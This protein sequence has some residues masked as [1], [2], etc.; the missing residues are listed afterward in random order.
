MKDPFIYLVVIMVSL[1]QFSLKA[2]ESDNI[3]VKIEAS[4]SSKV[5][6]TGEVFVYEVKLVSNSPE[7]AN[8]KL[9]KAQ[10][11]PQDATVI[12]GVVKNSKPLKNEK[13]DKTTYSWIISR[14]FI[15]PG[16]SG[17]HIV[18]PGEYIVFIPH[19][20]VVYHEFWG[21]RRTV[22]YEEIKV[23]C[24]SLDFK[25]KK[26]PSYNGI[27]EFSGCIGEFKVE[28]WFPP[29]K[30]L[31]GN[32]AYAIFSISGFGSLKDL[33]IPN[34]NKLFVQGCRLKEVEQK[35]EQSQKDERLFSE[36]TLTCRFVAE[37]EEF[38]IA[39][40]SFEFFNPR[41]DKFYK[42]ESDT[43]HWTKNPENPKLTIP[44]DV[45]EI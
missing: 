9:L 41:N 11:F 5:G 37:D 15:I 45:I 23:V 17:K 18:G 40:L 12:S 10:T 14:T 19:E 44:G 31:K 32:D 6:Y 30:I 36:I 28:G 34:L 29:G 16:N 39:P 22:E 8:V 26:I 1:I 13:K 27:Q 7:I 43:L 20:K 35:E 2:G 38:K 4:I 24:K 21:P 25:T 33:K 3:D 42:V